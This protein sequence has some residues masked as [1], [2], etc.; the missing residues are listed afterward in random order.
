VDLD[1]FCHEEFNHPQIIESLEATFQKRFVYKQHAIT[2]FADAEESD[3]PV[4]YKGQ[5]W[6]L[7]KKGISRAAGDFLR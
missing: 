1:L 7:V 6:E 5:T 4:S 2:Y 3:A